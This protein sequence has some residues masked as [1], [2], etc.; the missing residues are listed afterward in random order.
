MGHRALGAQGTVCAGGRYDGLVEQLGGKPVPA[1][2]FAM[3][4]ERLCLLLQETG[5]VPPSLSDEPDIFFAVAGELAQLSSI[6]IG[7][8]L[9]NEFPELRIMKHCGG[10]K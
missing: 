10:K 3:G 4:I 8:T 1:V 7:E 5:A 6:A 9:R 2:G